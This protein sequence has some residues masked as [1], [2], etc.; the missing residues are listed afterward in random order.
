MRFAPEGNP[1]IVGA[2]ALFALFAVTAWLFRHPGPALACLALAFVGAGFMAFFFRDPE[3]T[4]P[5]GDGLFV[6]GADGLVNSVEFM[7]ED[8]Y[9][10]CDAVRDTVFLNIHNVHINRMPMA[11][12]VELAT[13]TPGKFLEAWKAEA[14]FE[15]GRST[16]G[17]R[18]EKT[19]CLVRQIVG[20]VA[21]RVVTRVKEGETVERGGRFGLMK[22]GSRLDVFF[23][24]ADVEVLVEKG[25][26]V[27]AGET[28]V[29]RLRSET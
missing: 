3:R 20:L 13:Y 23:P 25:Q 9:L 4:P 16:V 18:G 22:F 6:S 28:P 15:N 12:T 14:S 10:K 1:F 19:S 7:R 17:V 21:R 27:R 2:F 29:A 11:G 5:T 26:R 8:V 24:A